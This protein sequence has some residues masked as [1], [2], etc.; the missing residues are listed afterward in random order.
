MRRFAQAFLAAVLGVS[1]VA[2]HEPPSNPFDVAEVFL[3]LNDTDGDLGLH[4]NVDGGG[5]TRLELES[6][7]ERP[8]LGLLAV[9]ALKR[10]GLTQLS[11]ES[12]EPSFDELDPAVFFRR[13]PEGRYTLEGLRADGGEF[14][15][16]VWLSHVLAAPVKATVSGFPAAESCDAPVLPQVQA[17]V[18]IDWDPVA[19]SHPDIGKQGRVQ[20]GRYQFFLEQGPIMLSLDLPP[21]VT[22]FTIPESLTAGKGVFKFEIIA[23]TTTGNNTAIESCFRVW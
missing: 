18:V 5:W 4:A 16:V 3:E 6:P 19:A 15:S 8:L 14:E 17:P 21:S 9:G 10:Q 1:L 12:A 20:I 22:A 2:G 23:R 11:F 13:F 7:R